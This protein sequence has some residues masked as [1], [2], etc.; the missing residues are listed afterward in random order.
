[1]QSDFFIAST[2]IKIQLDFKP[3]VV[4]VFRINTRKSSPTITGKRKLHDAR[5]AESCWSQICAI[6][7]STAIFAIIWKPG[8][9]NLHKLYMVYLSFYLLPFIYELRNFDKFN[10]FRNSPRILS[11]KKEQCNSDPDIKSFQSGELAKY[12]EFSSCH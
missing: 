5:I 4:D 12:L 6:L 8:F 2:I 3:Q 9:I 11:M 1:M 7:A 10:F